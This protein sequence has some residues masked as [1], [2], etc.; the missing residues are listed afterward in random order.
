MPRDDKQDHGPLVLHVEDD[1][2]IARAIGG[3]LRR[4][5]YEVVSVATAEGAFLELGARRFDVIVSD[6][7][8]AGIGS[9]ADVLAAA[10]STPFVFLT[11]DDRAGS[12]GVL[13]LEKPCAPAAIRAAIESLLARRAA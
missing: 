11:S 10:G 12:Y 13:R 3:M 4:A 5:G 1:A 6:F 8:L 9:G 7:N 2:A